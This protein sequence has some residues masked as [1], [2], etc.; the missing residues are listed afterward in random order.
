MSIVLDVMFTCL[1]LF[2]ACVTFHTKP[3][4]GE[5]SV[6]NSWLAAIGVFSIAGFFT[7]A[8]VAIWI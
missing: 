6:F 1:V 4:D 7:A 2:A 8:L 3:A 5:L